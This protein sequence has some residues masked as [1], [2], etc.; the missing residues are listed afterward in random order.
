MEKLKEEMIRHILAYNQNMKG[1]LHMS[2]P[3]EKLLHLCHPDDR[4]RFAAKIR[5][6]EKDLE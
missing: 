3:F 1:Y 4:E 5:K 6:I 2:T